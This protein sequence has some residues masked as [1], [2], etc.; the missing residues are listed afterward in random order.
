MR[1]LAIVLTL[2]FGLMLTPAMAT[3]REVV[4]GCSLPFTGGLS[5]EAPYFKDAYELGVDMINKSGGLMGKKVRLIIEDDQTNPATAISIY[6]KLVAKNK[7][8]ALFGPLG[9]SVTAAAASV[10]ERHKIPIISSYAASESLYTK[11]YKYHFGIA[12]S[13]YFGGSYSVPFIDM[14]DNFEKW[15]PKGAKKPTKIAII[16]VSGA[17]GRDAVDRCVK[18]AKEVGLDVVYREM[19]DAKTGDF[20]PMLQKIKRKGAEILCAV[21]YYND[22]VILARGIAKMKIKFKIVFLGTGPGLPEWKELGPIGYNYCTAYPLSPA[23][24]KGGYPEFV[25]AFKAKYGKDPLYSN[26]WA[27]GVAQVLK[28]AVDKAQSLDPRKIRDAIASL[29][30]DIAWCHVKFAPA[31]WNAGYGGTYISQNQKGK[32]VG[33]WPQEVAEGPVIYPFR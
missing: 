33:V 19:Y 32:T 24:K 26:A 13:R 2:I 30:M 10:A 4:I 6:E 22:S 12:A 14:I 1:V 11:G 23:W 5:S 16:G 3:G 15:A 25:K 17:Y 8:I 29:D 31:G 27:Y 18:R 28:A 21:S 7:A 9:S 20:T